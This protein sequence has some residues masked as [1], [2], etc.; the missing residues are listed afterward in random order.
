MSCEALGE[1]RLLGGVL[2]L[3]E[4]V[5]FLAAALVVTWL[6]RS[7]LLFSLAFFGV[8]LLAFLFLAFLEGVM[9]LE[10]FVFVLPEV[11]CV[12]DLVEVF[13]GF[14]S[15]LVSVSV[16]PVVSEVVR[17]AVRGIDHECCFEQFF[18]RSKVRRKGP[19]V[20]RV[21]VVIV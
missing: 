3:V 6:S 19:H 21:P 17:G 4:A 15:L 1:S 20:Q 5:L 16:G 18:F 11:C 12:N 14:F 8:V 2:F 9:L 10:K 13:S 7:P